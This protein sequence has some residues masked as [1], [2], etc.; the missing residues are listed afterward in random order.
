[1]ASIYFR[2]LPMKSLKSVL[3]AYTSS[4]SNT[5]ALIGNGLS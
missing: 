5:G 2:Y 4:H 3:A 1:M